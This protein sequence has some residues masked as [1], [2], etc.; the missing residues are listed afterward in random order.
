MKV[1]EILI[2]KSKT[3]IYCQAKTGKGR[4]HCIPMGLGSFKGHH[5]L[6]NL[7]CRDCNEAISKAEEQFLRVGPEGFIRQVLGINGRK[8]HEKTSP[9]YRGSSGA[10]PIEIKHPFPKT[11]TDVLW[12]ILPGTKSLNAIRQIGVSTE[13]GK[14]IQI[15]ISKR[16]TSK[17]SLL[18]LLEKHGLEKAKPVYYFTDPED[19]DDFLS[20]LRQIWPDL[21]VEN[22]PPPE[23]KE[24]FY[25]LIKV[26]VTSLYHRAIAKIGFH[27]FLAVSQ[28][29]FTGTEAEF[30]PIR[31][32][33][34]DGKGRPEDF[35]AQNDMPI[36]NDLDKGYTLSSWGHLLTARIG[37]RA[38][39]SR[40]QFFIG[41]E[42]L[43][44][45]FDIKL[46]ENPSKIIYPER[47][48]HFYSYYSEGHK[49]S[50]DGE[51]E[52]LKIIRNI[53]LRR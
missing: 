15:P 39:M 6:R 44:P 9:F 40:V 28:P 13:D 48:G 16:V 41:P 14:V 50:Y 43:P 18:E 37:R 30:S 22:M 36:L 47:F 45:I 11:K 3:C 20:I 27:Y 42:Y 31:S 33:I 5:I 53:Y 2:M 38:I 8:H 17:K 10:P 52:P 26:T 4:E 34:R 1:K 21:K 32:F 19:K 29:R 24:G 49:S 35:V 23:K 25:A 7:I 46:G 12:E 51:V